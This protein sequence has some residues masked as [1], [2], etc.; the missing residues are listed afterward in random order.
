MFF[1]FFETKLNENENDRF[2]IKSFKLE[3]KRMMEIKNE[4]YYCCPLFQTIFLDSRISNSQQ[5]IPFEIFQSDLFGSDFNQR[6][7]INHKHRFRLFSKQR[8]K[9]LIQI[10]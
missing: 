7:T 8:I 6:A 9:L 10:K 1:F 4:D 5:F 3:R 2:G